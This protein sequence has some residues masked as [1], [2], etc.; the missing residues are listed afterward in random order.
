M[1]LKKGMKGESMKQVETKRLILRQLQL[2]DAPIIEQLAGKYEVAKTTLSIPH[3]YPKGSGKDFITSVLLAESQGKM[4]MFAIVSKEIGQLIGVMN[5][6]VRLDHQRGELAYWLG[7]PYW[8]KGF[9]T[10]AA[11]AVLQYGFEQLNLNKIFA[12]AF[13]ENPGSW[14]I[15]EKIGMREEGVLK[16]HVMKWGQSVDLVYYGLLRQEYM[17]RLS[18]R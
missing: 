5:I 10:E 15:M 17:E 7:R 12:A 1:K 3:P 18:S 14:R 4:V 6:S 8:G 2:D 11:T 16:Q 9:G 13:F